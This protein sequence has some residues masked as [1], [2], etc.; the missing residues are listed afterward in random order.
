[1]CSSL[2]ASIDIVLFRVGMTAP[3]RIWN[4]WQQYEAESGTTKILI[5]ENQSSSFLFHSFTDRVTLL[6]IFSSHTEL[7]LYHASPDYL[8][9]KCSVD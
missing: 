7:K 5:R 1:M 8:C 2:V 4:G 6:S 9:S 3:F